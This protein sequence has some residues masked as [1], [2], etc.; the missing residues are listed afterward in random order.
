MT[1]FKNIFT[2]IPN[3][4]YFTGIGWVSRIVSALS[5]II[6]I[7]IVLGYL[8]TELYAVFVLV[9]GLSTWFVLMDFG[10]GKSLQNAISAARANGESARVWMDNAV[11]LIWLLIVL[12]VAVYSTVAYPFQCVLLHK[13]AAGV[14]QKQWYLLLVIG[15]MYIVSM[16][17]NTAFSVF[18]AEKQAYWVYIYQM[19]GAIGSIVMAIVTRYL[20]CGDYKLFIMLLALVTPLLIVSVISYVHAFSIRNIFCNYNYLVI[21]FLFIRSIKFC[22]YSLGNAVVLN[23]NYLIM[24]QTLTA[25]DIAIFSILD[26]GFNVVYFI[27]Q[28]LL[29]VL[30]PELAELFAQ[31]KWRQANKILSRNMWLGVGFVVICTIVFMVAKGLVILVLAPGTDLS[32][33]TLVI[34]VFGLYYVLRIF[35]D[36]YAVGLQSQNSLKVFAY[37]LPIQAFL[38]VVGMYYLSQYFAIN[39]LMLGLIL[40]LLLTATW[41]LP[42][43]YRKKV[44]QVACQN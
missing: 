14:S 43:V 7:N 33:P 10:L 12:S 44:V 36:T 32:L 25:Y 26:R 39:G 28:A 8:G 19:I 1:N 5:K 31:Q 3:Y 24:S 22:V 38:G 29:A 20:Y 15:N 9:N 35:S 11:I 17:L 16:L 41:I 23:S 6:A 42:Y 27:Y 40:A 13:I 2:A 4:Y 21:K 37:Y 34:C 30:W 18:F